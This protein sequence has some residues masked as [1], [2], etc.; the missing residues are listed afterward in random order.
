M[1][2]Q[3]KIAA[4]QKDMRAKH[5]L[6]VKKEGGVIVN[7]QRI[8]EKQVSDYK[9]FGWVEYVAPAKPAGVKKTTRKP[10]TA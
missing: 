9:G 10:K 3:D 5:A 6:V 1:S 2:I 4:L 8:L 7:V